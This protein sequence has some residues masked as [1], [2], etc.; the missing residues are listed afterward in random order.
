VIKEIR[1]DTEQIEANR[2]LVWQPCYEE[3][4]CAKLDVSLKSEVEESM[5]DGNRFHSTG[6]IHRMSKEL[7]LRLF[8]SMPQIE[9]ITKGL[10]SSIQVCTFHSLHIYV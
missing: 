5:I 7:R 4:D 9:K 2:E 10:C 6:W 1:A 3:Y 8:D